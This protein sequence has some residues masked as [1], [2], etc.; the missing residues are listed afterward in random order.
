MARRRYSFDEKKVQDYIAAG[1]GKGSGADYQPWLQYQDLSSIGRSHR[2]FGAKTQRVH[3]LFSDGEWKCFL[4]L[5]VDPMVSDIREQFPLDRMATWRC[6][7]ELGLKHPITTD[8]TPYV[9][10]I[11]FMVTRRVGDRFVH[12]PLTFKYD[13]ED[14]TKRDEELLAIQHRFFEQHNMTLRV[15]DQSFFNARIVN[16]VDRVQAH[17]DISNLAF[18]RDVNVPEIAR[19]LQRGV[20]SQ[21]SMSLLELC[22]LVATHFGTEPQVVFAVALHLFS[23]EILQTDYALAD[24]LERYPLVAISVVEQEPRFP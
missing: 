21:A 4:T 11:D 17:F 6:A 1:R 22:R 14:L 9:M 16:N 23:R 2:L 8:G 20:L 7:R 19:A 18:A 15:I 24:G 12:Q 5:Q 3:H 10:T 13:T